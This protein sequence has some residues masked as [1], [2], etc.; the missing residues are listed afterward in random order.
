MSVK[1]SKCKRIA[2]FLPNWVGDAVLSTPTL[3]AIREHFRDSH[4]AYVLRANIADL[5]DGE[6]WSDEKFV[7]PSG[8]KASRV[9][10]IMGLTSRLRDAEF[11]TAV[12]LTNSFRSA[13][14][15]KLAGINRRVGY[16][17]DGRVLLLTDYLLPD[18]QDGRYVPVAMREYYLAIAKYMGCRPGRSQLELFTSKKDDSEVDK[19]LRSMGMDPDR[20]IVVLNP[21]A[22]YG[23]SKCWPAER[24]GE[25]SDR[26]VSDFGV[27]T[28]VSYGPK[29]TSTADL[30][31]RSATGEIYS[32]DPRSLPLRLLKSLIRRSSLMVTNDTGPRHIAV[33]FGIPVVSIFG[34]THPV[35]SETHFPLERKLIVEVECGPCM[36]RTC[37]LGHHRCMIDITTD[38]VYQRAAEMLQA[39]LAPQGARG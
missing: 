6:P 7:V 14:M 10:T 18:R 5:L 23:P 13:L 3:R 1:R 19:L 9:P 39:R 30:V 26:L 15:A 20:P 27:Q 32:C 24:F 25:L 35:W 16:D 34:S 33:A 38:M 11:D 28:V 12:L 8:K 37:P 29:E 2:A 4:I 31:R 17:R 22:S 21:G 36:K